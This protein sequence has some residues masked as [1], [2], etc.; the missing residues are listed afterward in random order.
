M[1]LRTDLKTLLK[2]IAEDE[3]IENQRPKDARVSQAYIKEILA[4]RKKG[5]PDAT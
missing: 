2:E 1:I 5:V 3:A 4:K